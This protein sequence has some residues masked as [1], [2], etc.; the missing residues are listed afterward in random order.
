[1]CIRVDFKKRIEGIF[2]ILDRKT[3]LDEKVKKTDKTGLNST[4]TKFGEHPKLSSGSSS[5]GKDK[6]DDDDD[7]DNNKENLSSSSS[8]Q[9]HQNG[10]KDSK[11]QKG[12]QQQ[13]FS[14][15][16]EV[17]DPVQHMRHIMQL[18]TNE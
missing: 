9:L 3:R 16:F 2:H 1:M 12:K 11:Q 8:S 18:L 10:P 15:V 5:V 17:Q 14:A 4:M 6:C 13:E 7:D